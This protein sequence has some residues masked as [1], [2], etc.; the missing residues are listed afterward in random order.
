MDETIQYLKIEGTDFFVDSDNLALVE[1]GNHNNKILFSAMRDHGSYFSFDYSRQDKNIHS[2]SGIRDTKGILQRILESTQ[3]ND[4]PLNIKISKSSIYLHAAQREQS[5]IEPEEIGQ[6][7]TLIM[8]KREKKT[9]KGKEALAL[10]LA[11]QLP[12]LDILGHTFFV[13][14]RMGKLRPK[15]DFLSNGIS[16]RDIEDY[17]DSEKKCYIIPYDPK[18]K[19]F[20]PLDYQTI[21]EIPKDLKVIS[22]NEEYTLDPVG[23]TRLEGFPMIEDTIKLHHKA[24]S[25]NWEDIYVPQKIKENLQNISKENFKEEQV[26]KITQKKGRKM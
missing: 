26:G 12:T 1:K 16:F 5:N 22:F 7:N 23:W 13:D 4:I 25:A 15:D 18:K 10:R 24:T 2:I 9:D 11:G 3:E 21:T 8:S 6:A 14:V 17:Y 19:E 20:V